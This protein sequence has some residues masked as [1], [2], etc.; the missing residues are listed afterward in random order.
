MSSLVSRNVLPHPPNEAPRY[1]VESSKCISCAEALAG[2]GDF[3][4]RSDKK[5]SKQFAPKD[6]VISHLRSMQAAM[7]LEARL[8]KRL[9]KTSQEQQVPG[10]P[11]DKKKKKK[12]KDRGDEKALD[13][14]DLRD[15][16]L[17]PAKREDEKPVAEH[18]KHKKQKTKKKKRKT[19]EQQ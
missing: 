1:V 16:K 2:L 10:E 3:M 15:K 13:D 14:D 12:R 11:T 8:L 7:T 9:R 19:E 6:E 5:R 4:E 18:K 17:K